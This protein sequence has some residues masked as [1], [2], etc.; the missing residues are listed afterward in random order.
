MDNRFNEEISIPFSRVFL[1]GK[2]VVPQNSKAVILFPFLNRVNRLNPFNRILMQNLN[3]S[4]YATLQ[5]ELLTEKENIIK[6][7]QADTDLMTD[8]LFTATEW[9]E[10]VSITQDLEIAV[11]NTDN[12]T[13]NSVFRAAA[14]MSHLMSLVIIVEKLDVALDD[15]YDIESPTLLITGSL[16]K[17]ILRWNEKA[18]M[19]LGCEK[20]L[21]V[22]KDTAN[23]LSCNDKVDRVNEIAIN[24]FDLYTASLNSV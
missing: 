22:I 20:S 23:L 11:F 15:L 21:E 19:R 1:K 17:D 13:T 8:R 9:L 2:M 5:I 18:F 10:S 24:W 6:N 14:C 3:N 16:D 7:N 12:G 4:N